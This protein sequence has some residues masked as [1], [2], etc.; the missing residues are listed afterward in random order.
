MAKKLTITIEDNAKALEIRDVILDYFAEP[1]YQETIEDPNWVYNTDSPDLPGQVP[2]PISRDA[3][4]KAHVIN[5]LKNEY[6]RAK[7]EKEFATT[8]EEVLNEDLTID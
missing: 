8:R 5:A 2:N 1:K 3:F 6:H 4:F 7:L